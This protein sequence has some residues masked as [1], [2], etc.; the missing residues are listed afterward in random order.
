MVN[1]T[2]KI[3]GCKYFKWKEALFLPSWQIH[4]LPT[5]AQKSNIIEFAK[6]ADMVREYIGLPMIITSWLRPKIYNAMIG[7]SKK[8][9]HMKGMAI[10]FKCPG[11][12]ADDLRDLLEPKLEEFGIRMEKL[13]GA[14]WVHIDGHEPLPFGSRYFVP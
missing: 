4:V 13:P 10:D 12:S 6:K 2:K 7:G 11:V 8:S 9:Q 1:I 5:A 3:D 14:S